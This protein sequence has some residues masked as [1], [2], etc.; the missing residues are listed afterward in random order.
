MRSLFPTEFDFYPQT[1][2][3]PAQYEAFKQHVDEPADKHRTNTFIVK[4]S[5]G[6]QGTGIYLIRTLD[7]LTSH[8]NAVVQ[9]YID[10]PLLLDGLKFDLRLYVLVL[11]VQPLTAYLF[12]QGMARFATNR[13]KKPTD[14][15]LSDVFMHLTNYCA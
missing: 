7:Q 15:N 4:P 11:S 14:A 8:H 10:Q 3:L 1:W 2:T 13:Y 5:G 12:K 9:E 6:S